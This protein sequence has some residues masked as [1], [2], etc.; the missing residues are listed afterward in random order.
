MKTSLVGTANSQP[1]SSRGGRPSPSPFPTSSKLSNTN[2]SFRTPEKQEKLGRYTK[3]V[4]NHSVITTDQS[5]SYVYSRRPWRNA[6]SILCSLRGKSDPP[7][8]TRFPKKENQL[9]PSYLCTSAQSTPT[10]LLTPTLKLCTWV[11][12][13]LSIDINTRSLLAN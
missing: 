6:Y 9:S 11:F 4:T 2:G 13:K 12:P 5:P 8:P 7:V 3:R 1:L 10:K